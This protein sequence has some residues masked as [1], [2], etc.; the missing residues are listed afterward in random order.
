MENIKS[1]TSIP[2]TSMDLFKTQNEFEVPIYQRRYEWTI[3]EID[4]LFNDLNEFYRDNKELLIDDDVDV[5][6]YLGNIVTKQQTDSFGSVEKELLVDGQQRMTTLLLIFKALASSLNMITIDSE[7]KNKYKDALDKR[8]FLQNSNPKERMLKIKNQ[9]SDKILTAIIEDTISEGEKSNRY[10]QNYKRIK[11]N[12]NI[13]SK[14]ELEKWLK[15][16]R[17]TRL[18][19]IVLGSKDNEISVFDSINSKGKS[20]HILDLIRNYFFLNLEKLKAPENLKYKINDTF[21][22]MI[23][24]CFKSKSQKREVDEILAQRFIASILVL[25]T[26]D[27]VASENRDVLYNNFKKVFQKNFISLEEIKNLH[28]NLGNYYFWLSEFQKIAKEKKV[29]T[30]EKMSLAYIC[31]SKLMLYMP[32]L[33]GLKNNLKHEK[34]SIDEFYK[35]IKLLD[36]HN[37]VLS[38]TTGNKDNKFYVQL[39]KHVGKND[40]SY[41]KIFN[42]LTPNSSD[43]TNKSKFPTKEVFEQG[44]IEFPIYKTNKSLAKY[45]LTKIENYLQKEIENKDLQMDEQLPMNN[46]YTLE[47]IMPQ[48]LSEKWKEEVSELLHIKNIDKFGNLTLLSS[49]ANGYSSNWPYEKKRKTFENSKYIINNHFLVDK[50]KNWNI[51]EDENDID[52]RTKE[53][54][55]ILYKIH[56]NPFSLFKKP[57]NSKV[58]NPYYKH[59]LRWNKLKDKKSKWV[60][61]ISLILHYRYPDKMDV[62]E[63]YEIL[64]GLEKNIDELFSFKVIEPG[65]VSERL[66]RNDIDITPSDDFKKEKDLFKNDDGEYSLTDDWKEEMDE[67]LKK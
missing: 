9:Q 27:Y 4:Q 48:T 41:E 59:I 38:S 18:V 12:L 46:S 3:V 8:M 51:N 20:L 21:D 34:I 28:I 13:N 35:T 17:H 40:L 63:I 55:E 25:E 45:L 23:K 14:T 32:I 31:S 1:L 62:M 53:F 58:S 5:S 54:I 19:K 26:G 15:I 29:M 52:D 56:G 22:E 37:I 49:K 43:E 2:S 65:W 39:I 67:I 44:F 60:D 66:R 10:W 36:F 24:I 7:I 6:Y 33:F 11:E 30:S 50:Y 64:K 57:S 61:A 42:Y 16:L 47:H